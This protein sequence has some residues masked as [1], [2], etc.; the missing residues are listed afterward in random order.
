MGAHPRA[1]S[2]KLRPIYTSDR[3]DA[4]EG[5]NSGLHLLSWGDLHDLLLS[6]QIQIQGNIAS[7][8]SIRE[9]G[10][11]GGERTQKEDGKGEK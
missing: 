11:R 2:C 7:V 6:E 10:A 5:N 4:P 3:D 1:W 9:E 8:I